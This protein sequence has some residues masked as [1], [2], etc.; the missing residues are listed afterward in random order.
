[1]RKMEGIR[2]LEKRKNRII[3]NFLKLT[4]GD[5]DIVE[6]TPLIEDKV[7]AGKIRTMYLDSINALYND[8]LIFIAAQKGIIVQSLEVLAKEGLPKG[9]IEG[10]IDRAEKRIIDHKVNTRRAD[11]KEE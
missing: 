10:L 7:L 5:K 3:R 11:G 4:V 2:D 1:M 6:F 9:G 8:A